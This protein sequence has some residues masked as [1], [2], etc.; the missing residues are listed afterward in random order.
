VSRGGGGTVVAGDK[1]DKVLQ[2]EW[3][4]GSET[5]PMAAGSE[6]SPLRGR[7]DGGGGLSFWWQR[8]CSSRPTRT[9]DQ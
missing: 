7:G 6:S 1:G 8:R 5:G 2:H 3:V 4:M 9:R